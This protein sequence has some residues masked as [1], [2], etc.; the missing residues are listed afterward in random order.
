MENLENNEHKSEI[1]CGSDC[2]CNSK[3]GV[4]FKMKI[5]LFAIIIIVASAALGHSLLRKTLS[6]ATISPTGYPAALAL[7]TKSTAS[8]QEEKQNS[9]SPYEAFISLASFAS[10]DTVAQGVGG[11]FVLLVDNETEKTPNIAQAILAAKAAIESRVMKMGVFQL[12]RDCPDFAKVSSQLPPPGVLVLIK[13]K[14]MHG[15]RGNQITQTN[16]LQAFMAAMQPSSC[17]SSGSGH[18]SCK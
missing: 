16:L 18:S 15:V 1:P 11:V 13:G 5:I 3:K 8:P 17:C 7:N 12:K 2:S 6:A 14:G 10:L 9:S 4:S